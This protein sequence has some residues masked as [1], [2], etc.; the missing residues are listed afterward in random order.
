MTANAPTVDELMAKA[1]APGRDPRS[2]EYKAGVRSILAW[3][4]N[5]V[6]L[7]MPYALGST[8]ADAFFAGQDEGKAIWRD[9]QESD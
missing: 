4:L 7:A 3:R 1:F 2:A 5:S 6:P 8:Q 9:L